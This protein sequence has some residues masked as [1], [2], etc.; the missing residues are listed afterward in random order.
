MHG[1]MEN[2]TFAGFLVMISV[3]NRYREG[4]LI[5]TIAKNDSLIEIQFSNVGLSE[6]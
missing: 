5:P 6:V 4:D 3:Y 2:S 1:Y